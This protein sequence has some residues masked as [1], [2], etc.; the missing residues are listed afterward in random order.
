MT[1]PQT[2]FRE[3]TD[4]LEPDVD[5]LVTGGLERGRTRRRRRTTLAAVAAGAAVAV[6]AVG[7][8]AVP[9]LLSADAPVAPAGRGGED[10]RAV[11]PT[12]DPTP[13]PT[14]APRTLAVAPERVAQVFGDLVGGEIADGQAVPGDHG[15]AVA[16]FRWNGAYTS[17]IVEGFLDDRT[18]L[19]ECRAMNGG[20][21]FPCRQQADGSVLSAWLEQ[22][23][24]ED[25]GVTGR[26]ATLYTPDRWSVGVISY[27]AADPKSFEHLTPQPQLSADQ[28]EQVVTSDAWLR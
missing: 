25:G 12:P 10:R 6:L 9:Q 24:L 18:P 5:A 11:D 4:T 21:G 20:T 2:Y 28:A 7:A 13:E 27:N 22:Q 17:V 16:H 26:G 19:E 23:P 3:A 14:T 8:A 15:G 1:D